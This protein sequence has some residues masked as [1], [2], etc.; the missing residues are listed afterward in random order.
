ML[1]QSFRSCGTE[2]VA[3]QN[4]V[5]IAFMRSF[6]TSF[7]F[8]DCRICHGWLLLV[9]RYPLPHISSPFR[10]V[11]KLRSVKQIYQK[12]KYSAALRFLLNMKLCA[13]LLF[14]LLG[15]VVV[16][17]FSGSRGN[18]VYGKINARSNRRNLAFQ[19]QMSAEN[20][21]DQSSNSEVGESINVGLYEMSGECD[22]TS[23]YC[24]IDKASGKLV[25]PTV[26]EKERIFL[27]A[28][29]VG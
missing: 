8:N 1:C 7:F 16:H 9:A 5:L 17:G 22:P 29:Q 18:D 27:D 12:G 24:V 15:A 25:R 28:L 26:Q 14:A 13:S 2:F 20:N 3:S 21:S 10:Q 23:E 6:V 4:C 19:V 11:I